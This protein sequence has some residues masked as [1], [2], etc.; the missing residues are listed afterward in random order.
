MP[1]YRNFPISQQFLD[2]D[3][4][5]HLCVLLQVRKSGSRVMFLL[6]DKE[7]D[8][9]HTEQ[10]T[11]FKRETASLKLLP[12]QPRVIKMKKGSNGYGFYLRAGPEQKGKALGEQETWQ[13]N[14]PTLHLTP[15]FH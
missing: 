2:I 1:I 11:K 13:C 15:K 14:H 3:V 4:G 8:K 9:Y 12:H 6:V 7:T 5:P 10:N